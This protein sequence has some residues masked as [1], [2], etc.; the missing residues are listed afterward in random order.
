MSTTAKRIASIDILRGIVMV[1]M[2]LDHTRD[3]FSDYHYNPTD[4]SHAG[5]ALFFTRWITHFCA[6]IFIFLAGTSAFLSL[7]KGKTKPQAS[8][9]LLTRGIWLIILEL[10]IVRFGWQFNLE[11]QH[12]FVQVIWAIGWSMVA[13]S[14]LVFLP[15]ALILAFGL[16]LIFGHNA[17]DYMHAADYGS[18]AVWWNIF[19]EF[20]LVDFG[21]G[22]T[23]LVIYPLIPWIGVMAAGYCFGAIVKKEEQERNKWLYGIGIAAIVLFI[24]LRATNIYGDP[25]PWQQQGAWWRTVLSF[26]NCNKYPPSLLYLLM[27]IGPAIA[28]LPILDKMRNAAGRFFTVFGRV[29]LFYYILHIYLIHAMAL[30]GGMLLHVPYEYFTDTN[31]A[32]GPKP[33]WGFSLPVVYVA[34]LSAIAVLYLPCRWFMYIKLNHKKWWLSYL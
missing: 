20:G 3:Y 25:F 18:N 14:L 16:L 23:M 28:L 22:V 34:W 2:A 13:L 33:G 24:L 17:F 4:L 8:M 6:P 1:I 9:F 12:M 27:T 32:F 15:R 21:N 10:T 11:Y 26:I 31:K 29:P 30:I 5:T 7:S 19:H